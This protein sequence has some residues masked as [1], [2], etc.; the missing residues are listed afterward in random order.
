MIDPN[1]VPGGSS[2]MYRPGVI[3][4]TGSPGAPNLI[5]TAPSLNTAYVLDMN[6]PSPAWRPVGPMAFPRT[7]HTLTV[8]PDGH[9]LVTGGS[10]TND[11]SSQPVYA[12]EIWDAAQ[13]ETWSTMSSGQMARTYHQTALL[14]PDGRVLVAGSGG[15]CGA[16][17][18]FNAEI[19][20]PP[21]LFTGPRP[22]VT[23][24]SAS[25]GY[26]SQFFV[27]TPDAATIGSVALIRLG[28]VTH[29]IDMSQNYV[30]LAFTPTANGL[31]VQMS[32]N[33]NLAPPG[34]YML[35]IVNNSGVPSVAAIVTAH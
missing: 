29:E 33:A 2:A 22:I 18:Q 6:Q 10:Q 16:P 24:A 12:A 15:C 14:L 13:T 3:L 31:S 11:A 32:A 5:P 1:A 28:A 27:G 8:L 7:F 23:S 30:P 34:D 4:K 17:D 19:F 25:V 20:S 9:V 21:Y 26:G 35:F